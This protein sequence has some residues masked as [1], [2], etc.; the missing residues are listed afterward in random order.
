MVSNSFIISSYYIGD[1]Y[2]NVSS[3][4]AENLYQKINALDSKFPKVLPSKN[5]S[6]YNILADSDIRNSAWCTFAV[7]GEKTTIQFEVPQ[8]VSEDPNFQDRGYCNPVEPLRSET[9]W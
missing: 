6:L 8:P 9:G 1:I 4:I 3:D 2:I 5:F 7:H